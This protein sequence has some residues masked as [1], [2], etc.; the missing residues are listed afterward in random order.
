MV[1]IDATD[2][3]EYRTQVTDFVRTTHTLTLHA[4][5]IAVEAGDAYRLEGYPV[6]PRTAATTSGN[7]GRV[8]LTPSTALGT[9]GRRVV[10]YH[11]DFGDDS[12]SVICTFRV[13][14]SAP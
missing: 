4:L 3:R 13:L 12:E 2:N 9:P 6:L 14:P 1:V 10:V 8:Q 7:E 5:P 11:A